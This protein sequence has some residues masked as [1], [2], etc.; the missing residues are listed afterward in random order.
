[1]TSSGI[2]RSH[3]IKAMGFV[4]GY[5]NGIEFI[6]KNPNVICNIYELLM[7]SDPF[8]KK[9]A[10]NILYILCEVLPKGFEY[11]NRAAKESGL[12]HN[13]SPFNQLIDQLEEEDIDLKIGVLTLLISII[14][15]AP[16]DKKL[17]KF[18]ARLENMNTY[19]ILQNCSME[20]N[21]EL[22]RQ[23]KNF[24]IVTGIVISTSKFEVFVFYS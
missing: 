4:L 2:I 17:C 5:E 20:E 10:V 12:I 7:I 8:T 18:L 1:M 11:I 6:K 22:R 15:K 19:Q 9:Y 14:K 16:N 23:L 21:T 24:Q 13:R 3:G